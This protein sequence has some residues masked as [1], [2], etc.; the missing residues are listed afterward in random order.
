[1]ITYVQQVAWSLKAQMRVSL[2]RLLSLLNIWPHFDSDLRGH[3][4]QAAETIGKNKGKKK[5]CIDKAIS[6]VVWDF[7][8]WNKP[9][10]KKECSSSFITIF[11]SKSMVYWCS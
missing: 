10:K 5:R 4:Y 2:C 7:D 9:T 8:L 3:H 1:M 6:I 11:A